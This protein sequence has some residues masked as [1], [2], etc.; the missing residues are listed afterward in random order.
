MII[1]LRHAQKAAQAG[2]DGLICVA[3]G[4]GGHTGAASPF[5]LINEVRQFFDGT[6][7]LSVRLAQAVI[8]PPPR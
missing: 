1:S 5:G 6:V 4:A 8:L 7:L 2:V 3:A